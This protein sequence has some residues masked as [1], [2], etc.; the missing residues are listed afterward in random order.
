MSVVCQPAVRRVTGQVQRAY[1]DQA[2]MILLF[3]FLI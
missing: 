3:T 2:D 1:K